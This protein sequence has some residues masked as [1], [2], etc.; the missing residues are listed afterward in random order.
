VTRSGSSVVVDWPLPSI[1]FT[2]QQTTVLA[3]PPSAIAWTDLL[4]PAAV[5]VGLDW[6][7][8]IPSPVGNRFF[9]LRKP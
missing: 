5:H 1:G 7:V 3:S 4:S 2:L 9:R 8:T 6:T